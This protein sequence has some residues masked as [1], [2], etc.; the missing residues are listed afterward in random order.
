[1]RNKLASVFA[2]VWH[3]IN[4]TYLWYL[5]WL[6]SAKFFVDVHGTVFDQAGRVLLVRARLGAKDE[7]SL[8]GGI[9]KRGETWEVGFAREVREETGVS[10]RDARLLYVL[11]GYKLRVE[12]YFTAQ[13]VGSE[14][15][16]DSW[17][18]LEASWFAPDA[19]PACVAGQHRQVIELARQNI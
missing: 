16:V 10:I 14:L 19:L 7:W 11:S 4:G 3:K 8:P 6:F 9:V 17:E 1:M 18:V 15:H 12:A 13:S 2:D 5:I